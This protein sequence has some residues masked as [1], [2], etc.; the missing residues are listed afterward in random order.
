MYDKQVQHGISQPD[1]VTLSQT[2]DSGLDKLPV[3]ATGVRMESDSHALVRIKPLG[4]SV[5]R[6]VV[7]QDGKWLMV[8][9]GKF[10]AELGKPV[11]DA[12]ADEKAAGICGSSNPDRAPTPNPGLPANSPTTTAPG[13]SDTQQCFQGNCA[14][15][16]NPNYNPNDPNN[17]DPYLPD[18]KHAPTPASSY[19]PRQIPPAADQATPV[20]IACQEPKVK[21]LSI[22]LTCDNTWNVDKIVWT[23]WGAGADSVGTGIEFQDDCV[24]NCAQGSATY[25]PVTITLTGASPPD[26]HYTSAV[27]TNQ[28]T[29]K[30]KT[31]SL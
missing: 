27:I 28:N 14:V 6:E 3:T 22:M 26:F 20:V 5:Q 9:A 4:F 30:S 11:S 24:P 15:H 21:P 8:P 12:I 1:Y 7:Y 25:S 10:A 16:L 29:G 18:N 17:N 23:S 13:P 31:A 2:C 19:E